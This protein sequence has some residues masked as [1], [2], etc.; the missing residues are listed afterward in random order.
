MRAP[1]SIGRALASAPQRE[2]TEVA[3][4]LVGLGVELSRARVDQDLGQA[5]RAGMQEQR[6]A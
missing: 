4:A 2:R 5:L 1:Y 3:P 6:A